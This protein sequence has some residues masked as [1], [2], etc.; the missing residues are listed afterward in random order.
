MI[1]VSKLLELSRIDSSL[2][3]FKGKKLFVK[4]AITN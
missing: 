4:F 1:G 2:T 3:I